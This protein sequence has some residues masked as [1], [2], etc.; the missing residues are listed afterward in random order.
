MFLPNPPLQEELA[1]IISQLIHV[2][3]SSEARKS[4][5]FPGFQTS[6]LAGLVACLGNLVSA[7]LREV[8]LLGVG[9]I[10]ASC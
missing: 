2:V 8:R 10:G 9:D 3:H 1:N 4:R 5:C 7:S 6:L